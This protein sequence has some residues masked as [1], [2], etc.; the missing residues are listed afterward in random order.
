MMRDADRLSAIAKC[1]RLATARATVRVVRARR[2]GQ[3][4]PVPAVLFDWRGTLVHDPDES[5][6]VGE[7]LRRM[8]RPTTDGEVGTYCEQ[9]TLAAA[10]PEVRAA[11]Q[12]ADCSAVQHHAYAM[13]HFRLAGLD[14]ELATA[15]YDLDFEAASH[16]FYPDAPHVLRTL[17]SVGCRIALVSDIH[18]GLRPEFAAAG[19]TD[20]IDAFVLSYEHGV[21]KPDTRIFEIA[22]NALGVAPE[23]ALMVGDRASHDGGAAAA[24]IT[25]L[26]L[27]P[28]AGLAT[29]TRPSRGARALTERETSLLS[30]V[31]S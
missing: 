28:P 19:L 4:D 10:L 15:L 31:W 22:L 9:L 23:E 14:D 30:T 18:F 27:A 25:T 7:A 13:L 29:R 3:Y 26:L 6:W 24:G 11:E 21:Q 16:P 5:W 12:A 8:G 1:R 20:L 2:P 17:K